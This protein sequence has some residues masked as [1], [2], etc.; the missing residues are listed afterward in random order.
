MIVKQ[1]VLISRSRE[2]YYHYDFISA[3]AIFQ[4]LRKSII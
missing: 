3:A 2:I 1:L 4:G